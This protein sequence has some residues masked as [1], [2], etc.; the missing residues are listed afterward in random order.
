MLAA[1][2]RLNT[3]YEKRQVKLSSNGIKD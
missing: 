1:F 3:G 2:N